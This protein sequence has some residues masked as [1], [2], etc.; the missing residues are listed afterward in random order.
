MTP[1][2]QQ[3]MDPGLAALVM[4]MQLQGVAADAAQI[5]HRTGTQAF[6]V[7]EMLRCAKDYGLKVR[8]FTTN[9][10]RLAR[11]PMPALAILKDGSYLLL[12]KVGDDKLLAQAPLEPRPRRAEAR[13]AG[14]DLGRAHGADDQAALADRSGAALR[15]HLV[16]GRHPQVP[17][18]PGRGPAGARSSCSCS[19][20]VSPLFF[21]VVIDKVLVHRSI[22]TLDILLIGLRG[23]HAVRRR[24][25][26]PADLCVLAHHQPDRRRAWRPAVPPS[27]GP[28][29][30][31]LPVAPGRRFGGARARAG[32]H[33]QLPDRLGADAGD[34]PVLHRGLHR[35]DVSLL[36][37]ADLDR[38]GLNPVLRADLGRGDADVPRAAAT[39]SSSAAP[40]TRP[41]WSR[42]W[43]A[44]RP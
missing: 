16:H 29:D 7:P 39:R 26:H 43:P 1:D 14:S 40:R 22:S 12:G 13:G 2:S 42:A 41:S 15:R 32:E 21:Q 36:A 5:R 20:L 3:A 19:A 34:R 35:G 4:M 17:P 33:P 25:G 31:L 30:R 8:A 44:S 11:T 6:G 23:D 28:A 24:A 37:A 9:W 10:S 38:A 27:A 18:S